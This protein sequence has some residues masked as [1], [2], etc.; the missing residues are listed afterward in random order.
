MS[1]DIEYSKKYNDDKFEY[2]HVILPKEVAKRLPDPQRLLSETEWRSL[3]VQQSLGWVHYEVHRPEPHILL[4]RRPVGTDPRTGLGTAGAVLASAVAV[5]VPAQQQ[6]VLQQV[7]VVG[8]NAHAAKE[9][10][11]P[12]LLQA[13]GNNGNA[14][15]NN[16]V[17]ANN[18]LKK[19]T[20]N[21]S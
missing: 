5:A 18:K 8:V 9:N 16:N 20:S 1:T 7:A 11:A 13:N 3:G 21:K 19:K 4:F 15:N 17:N 14:L 10:V 12:A 6:Q 2:R